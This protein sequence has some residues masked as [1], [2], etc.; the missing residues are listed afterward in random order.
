[1]SARLKKKKCNHD[2]VYDAVT[3]SF[4][5][6]RIG[7]TGSEEDAKDHRHLLVCYCWQ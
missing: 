7:Y 3:I 2:Q 6:A 1:M 4:V 5:K